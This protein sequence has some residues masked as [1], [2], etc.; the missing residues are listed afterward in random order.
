MVID[1]LTVW[2]TE[3]QTCIGTVNRHLIDITPLCS[4]GLGLNSSSGCSSIITLC[5][6]GAA[7]STGAAPIDVRVRGSGF[8]RFLKAESY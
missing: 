1:V 6:V 4:L 7:V 2:L 5:C 8:E 3:Q